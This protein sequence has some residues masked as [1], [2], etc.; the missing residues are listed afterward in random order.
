MSI[1][2][3]INSMIGSA[4]HAIG[5]VKGYQELKTKKSPQAQAS[6]TAK[7]SAENAVEAKRTQISQMDQIM[8]QK[9]SL[10]VKVADLP[11]KMQEKIKE[12]LK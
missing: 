1:Q 7:Q 8:N 6:Q 10:G 5:F 3:S 2:G 11:E 4:S 12:T 9:T